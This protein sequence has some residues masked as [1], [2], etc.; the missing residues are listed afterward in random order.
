[1]SIPTAKGPLATIGSNL[2]KRKA[3]DKST[4]ARP[5]KKPRVPK[6]KNPPATSVLPPINDKRRNLTLADWM[7]VFAYIDS[8]PDANQTEIVNYFRT[9][10]SGRLI[11]DQSIVIQM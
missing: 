9:H 5:A 6:P 11:F 8:H 3:T 10:P 2:L 7:T 4:E 1:M